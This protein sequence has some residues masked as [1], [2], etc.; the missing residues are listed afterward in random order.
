MAFLSP[1]ASCSLI[2]LF[3]CC[4]SVSRALASWPGGPALRL[5]GLLEEP[6][7]GLRWGRWPI[8]TR[9]RACACVSAHESRG[10]STISHTPQPVL[11][12]RASF[13]LPLG[14]YSTLLLGA[15]CLLL[16]VVGVRN[17]ADAELERRRPHPPCCGGPF[18]RRLPGLTQ[19]LWLLQLFFF[20][21]L[22]R[23]A[24]RKSAGSPRNCPLAR[25]CF[26]PIVRTGRPK[27][28]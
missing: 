3:W 4:P 16:I 28:L 17:A 7:P 21:L 12:V 25:G 2:R 26:M 15:S 11:Q 18:E 10:N 19:G 23:T 14:V 27:R 24:W 8:E 22:K 6:H 5:R 20:G 9:M 13:P 1:T